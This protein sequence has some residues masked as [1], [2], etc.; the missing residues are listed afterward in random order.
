MVEH[1]SHERQ[2]HAAGDPLGFTLGQFWQ[3]AAS[4]LMSNALRGV[5]AEFFV[6]QAVGATAA[7]RLEWDACDVLHPSGLKIEVKASGYLQTWAEK[8]LSTPCF[9][10]GRKLS[11][12]AASNTASATRCRPA[13]VYVFALLVHK[14]RGTADP[15]DVMQWEFYVVPT[16]LLD[17]K[18][19]DKKSI[20]LGS[21]R[22]HGVVP[23]T[24]AELSRQV[25]AVT[26]A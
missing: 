8:A 19:G 14:E 3:W 13:H 20:R 16:A 22:R 26:Q 5:L 23:V 11:W 18:C 10:I 21:L 2:F 17:E 9:D 1:N 25:S 24:W 15:L 12:D 4:D 7:T 6:A